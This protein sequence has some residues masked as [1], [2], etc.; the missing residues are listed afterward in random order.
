M[1]N[2]LENKGNFQTLIKSKIIL[3]IKDVIIMIKLKIKK[4]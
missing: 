1:K 2:I 4:N 3:I